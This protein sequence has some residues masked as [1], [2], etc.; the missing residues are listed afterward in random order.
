MVDNGNQSLIVQKA[1]E[2]A[3]VEVKAY[4]KG[5]LE[6][7][8]PE[9]EIKPICTF[10]AKSE[11]FDSFAFSPN[12]DFI[13][14]KTAERVYLWDRKQ[15]RSIQVFSH[16]CFV[17]ALTFSKDGQL[18]ITGDSQKRLHIW[19]VQSGEC[20]RVIEMED[21]ASVIWA[22]SDEFVVVWGNW[23]KISA[24]EIKTGKH[25]YT[26]DKNC[27]GFAI[28]PDEKV[29]ITTNYFWEEDLEAKRTKG[30][31]SLVFWDIQT[32][33]TLDERRMDF[34]GLELGKIVITPDGRNIISL[35]EKGK[36]I[37]IIDLETGKAR[38]INH[39]S[40]N[41]K[42]M[43][44]I[45]INP[46][47]EF[48]LTCGDYHSKGLYLWDINAG[49]CL[50]VIPGK[51]ESS[52]FSPDGREL[53]AIRPD[54]AVQLWEINSGRSHQEVN[55]HADSQTNFALSPKRDWFVTDASEYALT[56]WDLRT[57]Q[58]CHRLTGHRDF[59]SDI[60]ISPD[61]KTLASASHD[62]TIRL[63]DLGSGQCISIW[64]LAR[65]PLSIVF[66]PD[67]RWIAMAEGHALEEQ[68]FSV[69]ELR[70]G[71][72]IHNLKREDNFDQLLAFSKNGRILLIGR[73]STM[74][75]W[76]L[77]TGKYQRLSFRTRINSRS[78]SSL[79]F[80]QEKTIV[81]GKGDKNIY[82]YDLDSGEEVFC[83]EGH[84]KDISA[85]ALHAKKQTLVSADEDNQ[86]YEWDLNTGNRL[87]AFTGLPPC[88]WRWRH[89]R[90]LDIS[91]DGKL[92]IAA[93]F[94]GVVSFWDYESGRFLATAYALDEGYLWMTPPDEFAKNGWVHTNRPDLISLAGV[95]PN[96][97]RLEYLKEDDERFNEYMQIYNDGE[98]VM[99]R[100]ND[101]E[102]YLELLRLR[103]N[104]KDGMDLKLIE[105]RVNKD[106][107][108]LPKPN[109]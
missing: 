26:I 50:E 63:W 52:A 77:E 37:S 59:I 97:D 11:V 75:L 58:P 28:T 40:I 54:G 98:M 85:I 33:L 20:V 73:S 84:Q 91:S 69:R 95:D 61:N 42:D 108:Y 88:W 55:C 104:N 3:V 17:Q 1:R 72:I 87:R 101:W 45:R 67:G 19:D 82:G 15:G 65:R 107:H 32:G 8:A 16:S 89:I 56:I 78:T 83:L 23:K 68:W 46:N 92:L 79:F 100:I 90:N 76:D 30:W 7:C 71:R 14:M 93:G 109:V 22:A 24:W 103:I 44:E 47:G 81:I 5:L 13:A 62:N 60:A 18:L 36:V 96:D 74:C 29:I 34:P 66:S 105:A 10:R 57:G 9:K 25:C 48:L 2:Q 53:A 43:G 4:E 51:W 41:S 31:Y 27:R 49:S 35:L 38:Q 106:Q 94:D 86:V 102:R 70:T 12:S 39:R 21:N 6:S 64:R 80:Q 99:T